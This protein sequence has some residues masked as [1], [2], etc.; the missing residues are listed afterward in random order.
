MQQREKKEILKNVKKQPRGMKDILRFSN[1]LLVRGS[2]QKNQ[3][4]SQQIFILPE[5]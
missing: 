5:F 4:N 1:K 3:T 2:Q